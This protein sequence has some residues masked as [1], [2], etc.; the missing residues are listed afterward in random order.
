[1]DTP[2]TAPSELN[3]DSAAAEFTAL[4]SPEPVK[5]EG[6]NAADEPV[7]PEPAKAEPDAPADPE[8]NAA[9]EGADA[10]TVEIDGKPVSL[11]KAQIAE[12]YKDGLRQAD[13]TRKTMELAE[14]R[15]VA[16]AET[17]KARDERNQYAANL[18]RNAAMLE[19]VLQ[20][21]QK[22]DWQAL[23]N[24]DPVEYLKQQHLFNQRQ[25]AL[26]QNFQERQQLE[27]VAR[28]EQA[29]Q[30]KSYVQGQQ[31]ELLAKIPEWK[32]ESKAKAQAAEL[33]DYLKQQGYDEQTVNNV[34]DHKAVVMARKAML[35]DQMIAK[36]SAAAKK[37]STLPSKVERPGSGN[38]P[39]TDKRSA[40][41]QRFAKSGRP[42]DA[43]ALFAQLI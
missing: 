33:R 21:Q 4:L 34:A 24:S 38:A 9:D 6:E 3:A 26:Q 25:A 11:T 29:E 32:D 14:N 10:V 1:M 23:L 18:Q 37:V 17:A 8:A 2:E 43:A 22:T 7:A 5:K 13:Y 28:A 19:G 40:D 15:K 39:S 16:D 27:T 20:E 30:M 31:A 41:Y 36:A 35:Y 12:A 42:E